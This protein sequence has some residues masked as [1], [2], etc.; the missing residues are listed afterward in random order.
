MDD[1]EAEG[2]CVSR[3]KC[4]VGSSVLSS[5]ATNDCPS[6]SGVVD[7]SIVRESSVMTSVM[8]KPK[9]IR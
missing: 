5:A 9:Q 8:T 3:R 7:W 4:D 1:E 6:Q 2:E